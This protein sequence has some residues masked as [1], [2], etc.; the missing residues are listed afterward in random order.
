MPHT[1]KAL[2]ELDYAEETHVRNYI[3]REELKL[4]EHMVNLQQR[5]FNDVTKY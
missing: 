4:N 5:Y 1:H 3:S 2:S